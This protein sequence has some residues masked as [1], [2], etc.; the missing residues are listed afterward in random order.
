MNSAGP[1]RDPYDVLIVRHRW[2][3]VASIVT[4]VTFVALEIFVVVYN[5]VTHTGFDAVFWV[6]PFMV[7]FM[8][9]L[10]I[11]A[12]RFRKAAALQAQSRYQAPA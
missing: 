1:P 4:W 3:W 11:R 6:G 12:G 2:V 10:L 7:V 8:A 9:I 5:V